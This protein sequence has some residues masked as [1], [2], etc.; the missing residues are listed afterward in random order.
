M[1]NE[2]FVK[3]PIEN[4]EEINEG[5]GDLPEWLRRNEVKSALLLGETVD[6]SLVSKVVDEGYADNL[7]DDEVEKLGCDPFIIAF[8]LKDKN[9]RCVVTTET[10][11]PSKKR[12]NRHIPDVCSYFEI[13]SCNTFEFIN[14]LDFSTKWKNK[15]EV[16]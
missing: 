13:Q 10:S 7:S 3:I 11:R 16:R 2:G 6:P 1:G 9:N 15:L 14:K 8:A 5:N 12:A 4:Y